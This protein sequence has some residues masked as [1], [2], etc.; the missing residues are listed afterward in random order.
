MA[1]FRPLLR[2]GTRLYKWLFRRRLDSETRNVADVLR[3][4]PVFSS[5]SSRALYAMAEAVHRRTY[6]RGEVLYY[7]GD[8]GLGLY[9][10]ESGRVRLLTDESDQTH[11]LRELGAHEVAGSL[12][13]LGD[14]RRL[15][16]AEAVTDARVLGFFRP[17]LKNI[18]RRDPKAGAEIQGE[19]AR[20]IAT[21]YVDLVH[22]LGTHDGRVEALKAHAGQDVSDRESS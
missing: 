21:R 19:L 10:V 2:A 18:A 8:P 9:V 1:V 6:R 14:F 4:I 5:L 3:Q 15:E 12:S 11:T 16:T 22:R 7:E 17:D 20:H 13:V